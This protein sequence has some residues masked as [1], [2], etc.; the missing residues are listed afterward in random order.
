MDEGVAEATHR[1]RNHVLAKLRISRSSRSGRHLPRQDKCPRRRARMGRTSPRMCC[2]RCSSSSP[3]ARRSGRTHCRGG[4]SSRR[5]RGGRQ[6]GCGI[7]HEHMVFGTKEVQIRAV[8]RGQ[9]SGQK[10]LVRQ[11][12]HPGGEG[13]PRG[14]FVWL[15]QAALLQQQHLPRH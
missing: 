7:R 10:M 5:G 6:E 8:L 1:L 9:L 4:A 3:S 15:Q 12:Q 2:R 11:Q 13:M 14:T